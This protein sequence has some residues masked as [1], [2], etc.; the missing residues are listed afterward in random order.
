ML[1]LRNGNWKG[2][3]SISFL[4]NDYFM[5][6]ISA[7][8][9]N[10]RVTFKSCSKWEW[11]SCQ[12]SPQTYLKKESNLSSVASYTTPKNAGLQPNCSGIR[13]FVKLFWTTT[14][15]VM[16]TRGRR[17]IKV[18]LLASM[19]LNVILMLNLITCINSLSLI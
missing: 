1:C 2:K 9:V 19:S 18:R 8:G 17:R 5:S 10:L 6:K 7:H 13:T 11:V 12:T 15:T 16:T 3:T 4:L 14:A